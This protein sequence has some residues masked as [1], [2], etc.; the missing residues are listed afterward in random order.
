MQFDVGVRVIGD[1]EQRLEDVVQELL[2]VFH[3]LVR[4][5]DIAGGNKH[6]WI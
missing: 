6:T 1:L 3:Y 4:F 5:E 2:E